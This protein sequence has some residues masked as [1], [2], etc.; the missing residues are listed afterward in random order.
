MARANYIRYYLEQAAETQ[1]A[2]RALLKNS[3][4]SL[5]K[6]SDPDYNVDLLQVRQVI[7]NIKSRS[8]PLTAIQFGQAF[9]VKHLGLIGHAIL[10]CDTLADCTRYWNH[11]NDLVGNVLN[12]P[13][14][15]K[16]DYCEIEFEE[17]CPLGDSLP[18]C[19]EQSLASTLQVVMELTGES[20]R[21]QSI[22]LTYPAN[23]SRLTEHHY[24]DFFGCD[25]IFNGRRN[26]AT[27]LASD[28][29]RK[30]HTADEETLTLFDQHCQDVLRKQKE[31]GGI[32]QQVRQLFLKYS[33]N[34]PKITE[35][36]SLLQTSERSLRRKL[37]NEGLSYSG[38]R[39]D[40][41]RDLAIEYLKSTDLAAKEIAY[42]LGYDN[43]S[44][45]RRAFK[46]QTGET[47]KVF[48]NKLKAQP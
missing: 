40:F 41:R 42:L 44:S 25:V 24:R 34:P 29:D 18:F 23:K 16:D 31:T 20:I 9:S 28:F 5:D 36:A 38:L 26:V 46:E 43:I 47:V 32:A 45:F 2:R 3:A 11:F 39:N 27:F 48:R 1:A 14:L 7:N 35:I 15:I 22:E 8:H 33:R 6:L 37:D 12:Y 13:L 4:I 19:I 30:I 17:L 10:S 21:Y